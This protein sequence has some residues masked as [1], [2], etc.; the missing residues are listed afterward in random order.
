MRILQ[1]GK[2][3]PIEG[4]IE[5]MMYDLMTG[6]SQRGIRCDMMCAARKGGSRIVRVNSNASLICCGSLAMV[7]RTMI[8][9]SMVF[10]LRKVC[11]SYDIIHVHHPDPMAGLALWLSGFKGKVVLH[12]H[13]D[14]LKQKTLLKLYRPLQDWLIRRAARIV[15]T[16]PVYVRESPFLSGCQEKTVAFPIGI[17]HHAPDPVRSER[18]RNEYPGKKIV[19]FIGRLVEYKG[20]RYLIDAASGLPSDYVVLIGG[21][22]PLRDSLQS[23]I[24][25]LGLGDKVKLI[26]RV[27]E[28]TLSSYFEACSVFCISSIRK[29]EAFG[30]VQVKA[31]SAGRPV[32]ATKIPQSGVSW[33]NADGV[34]GINV[35][36]CDSKA[37]AEAVMAI[38]RD[39]ETYS[40][41][42][43]GARERYLETFTMPH[44]IDN[45]KKLYDGVLK[46][47]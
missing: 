7:A 17:D 15:G 13:S 24:D 40:R 25:S 1:L 43:R 20:L 32:V 3:Y 18:I 23:R 36:V 28:E 39:E 45:C 26:G 11:D 38:T 31:M 2:F 41:F 37:L 12:W 6:L 29:T 21:A 27:P 46:E 5:Q 35:P 9:P 34:S 33:V 19:L 22:G 8:S 47:G 16:T 4:G 42:C 44:M 30:M 14:I 10:R